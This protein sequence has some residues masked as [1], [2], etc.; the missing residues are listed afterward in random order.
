MNT[1]SSGQKPL[2]YN[3]E[4]TRK[5]K[6]NRRL[7][8]LAKESQ[9]N[10][11]RDYPGTFPGV[12]GA[13]VLGLQRDSDQP[14]FLN[15][16]GLIEEADKFWKYLVSRAQQLF[17]GTAQIL[18]TLL[19]EDIGSICVCPDGHGYDHRVASHLE[20]APDRKA[21]GRAEISDRTAAVHFRVTEPS[22]SISGR[23]IVTTNVPAGYSLNGNTE[24]GPVTP[25][26]PP[27][28]STESPA[29]EP[30][31]PVT[32]TSSRTASGT[33]VSRSRA[34]PE[35]SG[36]SGLVQAHHRVEE[37]EREQQRLPTD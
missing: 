31:L 25:N 23:T 27:S 5:D 36:L 15:H 37:L 34:S 3:P 2:T 20:I 6:E 24:T 9:E 8:R 14:E 35:E 17:Q 13:P 12:R 11:E 4:I 22:I 29:D 16:L 1:R 19:R 32:Q 7:A 18:L 30:T 28:I 26:Q 33:P 10:R 21:A